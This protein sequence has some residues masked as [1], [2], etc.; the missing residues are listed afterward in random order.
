[1]LPK[2]DKMLGVLASLV[3]RLRDHIKVLEK[4]HGRGELSPHWNVLRDA[5]RLVF[6]GKERFEGE[7]EQV[8][9]RLREMLGVVQ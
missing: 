4:T 2:G 8:K 5:E 3:C 1:M 7:A 6:E 9:A